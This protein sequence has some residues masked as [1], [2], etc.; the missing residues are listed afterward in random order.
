MLG[1]IVVY[2]LTLYSA[3]PDC[4]Q[5]PL[6]GAFVLLLVCDVVQ[7]AVLKVFRCF[8]CKCIYDSMHL[9]VCTSAHVADCYMGSFRN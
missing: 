3:I 1:E 9:T 7:C 6:L 5:I 4:F 2:G 8:S